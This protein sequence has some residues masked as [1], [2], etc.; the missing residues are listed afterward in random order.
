MVDLR[1]GH[2]LVGVTTKG[3]KPGVRPN[4][5]HSHPLYSI[6]CLFMYSCWGAKPKSINGQMPSGT[7]DK[8]KSSKCMAEIGFLMYKVYVIACSALLHTGLS[9]NYNI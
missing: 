1:L 3:H 6:I 9:H 2:L 8:I 7:G 5:I 4:T